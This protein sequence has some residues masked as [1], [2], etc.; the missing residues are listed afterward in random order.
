MTNDN[1]LYLKLIDLITG[2]EIV[3]FTTHEQ[4]IQIND[5]IEDRYE[6]GKLLFN[7]WKYKESIKDFIKTIESEVRVLR[8][9]N[10]YLVWETRSGLSVLHIPP[11]EVA[12]ACEEVIKRRDQMLSD[13]E[14]VPPFV[15]SEIKASCKVSIDYDSQTM[16][17]RLNFHG[18]V[19][20]KHV[21]YIE[22]KDVP[23][24][25][26]AARLMKRYQEKK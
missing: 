21:M 20:D 17:Y 2:E 10:S 8:G 25:R 4:R 1:K 18:G 9:T 6:N 24:V 7:S 23:S 13:A 12:D 14:G 26:A 19:R 5:A 3:Y 15:R 11:S 22:A 16:Q